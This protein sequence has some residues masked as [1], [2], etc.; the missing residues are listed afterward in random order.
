MDKFIIKH[1]LNV[2]KFEEQHCNIVI[3]CSCI[4]VPDFE[5]SFQL[6]YLTDYY[7]LYSFTVYG[8]LETTR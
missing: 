8:S 2:H 4:F 6:L 3:T 1:F 5:I 7:N